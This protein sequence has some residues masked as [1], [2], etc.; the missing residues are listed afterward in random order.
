MTTVLE[1]RLDSLEGALFQLADH[2][3]RLRRIDEEK[4]MVASKI[5]GL[6]YYYGDY[7][8]IIAAHPSKKTQVIAKIK[9]QETGVECHWIFDAFDALA[10][11]KRISEFGSWEE[12]KAA[13]LLKWAIG[14]EEMMAGFGFSQEKIHEKMVGYCEMFKIPYKSYFQEVV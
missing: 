8:G 3:A 12:Y 6:P 2:Y 9:H 5:V 7:S 14:M 1:K 10:H 11:L 13:E 4:A